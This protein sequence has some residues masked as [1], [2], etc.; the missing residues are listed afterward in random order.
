MGAG[1][2]GRGGGGEAGEGRRA[3]ACA[4][5]EG[6]RWEA[7]GGER[8]GNTNT[9]TV[10]R[11]VRGG[12]SVN[13]LPG[14]CLYRATETGVPRTCVSVKRYIV[15]TSAKGAFDRKYL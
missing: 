7:E 1:G 5:R 15:D 3:K 10:K 8:G 11:H 4:K 9:S 6:E 14:G 13:N 12:S 2:R